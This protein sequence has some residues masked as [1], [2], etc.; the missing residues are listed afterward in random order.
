M[1]RKTVVSNGPSPGLMVDIKC[2][3]KLKR[4]ISTNQWQ[5]ETNWYKTQKKE[6]PWEN[7]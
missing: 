1:N 2:H 7:I 4:S 3:G 6:I 5:P